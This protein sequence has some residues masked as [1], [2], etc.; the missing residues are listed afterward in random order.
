MGQ[1]GLNDA[2][3]RELLAAMLEY[4]YASEEWVFPLAES[5]EGIRFDQA[6]W[7]PGPEM[8][9]I[10]DIVLHVAVWNENIV[11]RVETGEEVRPEE[12]AWPARAEPMGEESWR[13][14]Q[15]RLWKSLTALKCLVEEGSPEKIRASPYGYPDLVCRFLHIAYHA[16]QIVK[17][18]ECQ[19]W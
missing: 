19:G 10:W 13:A 4:S 14:A 3:T 15:D 11:A 18:R 17:I 1:S 5:L 12:G 16:G 9:G 6:A 8:M 7:R 2:E